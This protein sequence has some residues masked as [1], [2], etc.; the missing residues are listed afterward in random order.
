[1]MGQK[2]TVCNYVLKA[3]FCRVKNINFKSILEDSLLP[4]ALKIKAEVVCIVHKPTSN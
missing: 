3:F 2:T 1:M 4:E